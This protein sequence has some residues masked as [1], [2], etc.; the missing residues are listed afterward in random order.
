MTLYEIRAAIKGYNK[1][2]EN[3]MKLDAALAY[4]LAGLVGIAINDPKK[5]PKSVDKAFPGMFKEELGKQQDW[6]V[7]K[8]RIEDYNMYMKLKRGEKIG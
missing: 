4:E 2:L 1:N 7:M 6:R 3:K 5:Y 8:Q